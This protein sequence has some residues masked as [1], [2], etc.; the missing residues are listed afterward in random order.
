MKLWMMRLALILALLCPC[1]AGAETPQK[2]VYLTFDDG[3]KATTPELL[4]LLKELDVP[5]TFFLVGMKI[6]AFPEEA[7]MLAASGHALGCHTLDHSTGGIRQDAAS[8]LWH[9]ERFL[10]VAREVCGPEFDTNLFRF[11]GGSS[12]YPWRSKRFLVNAGIAWFD[13]NALTQDTQPDMDA[14]KVLKSVKKTAGEDDVVILLCHEGKRWTMEA[15][16]EIVSWFRERGYVFRKLSLS[17]EDREILS[18][19]PAR[20]GLPE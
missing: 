19:C 1:L 16:P 13:W 7:R 12:H 6:R 18:R 14:E 10:K 3:P 8:V 20:M 11:P 5:A 2:V 9:M 4:E 17:Q 15:L